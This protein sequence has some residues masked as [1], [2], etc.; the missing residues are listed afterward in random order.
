MSLTYGEKEKGGT[1]RREK[2]KEKKTRPFK[3]RTDK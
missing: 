1:A 2:G 3:I